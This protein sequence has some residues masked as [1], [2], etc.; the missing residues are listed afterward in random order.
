MLY[1][2][3]RKQYPQGTPAYRFAELASIMP[4]TDDP[5]VLVAFEEL[6]N[7]LGEQLSEHV[8]NLLSIRANILATTDAIDAEIGRLEALRLERLRRAEKLQEVVAGYM[9]T[10]DSTEIVTDLFT[11]K[12]KRNPPKVEIL[13]EMQVPTEYIRRVEKVEMKPDKKAIADA[14]K[15][16]V[17]V[18]GCRLL[19]TKRI[20]IK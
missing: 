9:D 2:I 12:L 16:G 13:D 5:E 3:G 4:N 20:E 15:N 6:A 7:E 14:L 8:E 10:V 1:N 18:D 19:L 17:P 11:V